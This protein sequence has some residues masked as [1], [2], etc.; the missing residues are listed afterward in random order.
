MPLALQWERK[1]VP[2]H[3]EIIQTANERDDFLCRALSGIYPRCALHQ[4]VPAATIAPLATGGAMAVY[5]ITVARPNQSPLCMVGKIP[6]DRRIVYVSDADQ[7]TAETTTHSLLTRLVRIAAHLAC[8]A[9]GIFPRSGGLWHECQADGAI[10]HLLMEEFIP[11]VSVERLTH[12]YDEQRTLGQLTMSD[13]QQC[14]TTVERL[15]VATF[16]RLWDTLGRQTFTSDPSPWNVLVRQAIPDHPDTRMAT[17][18][19]LHSLEDNATLSFVL[20]RLAAVYGMRQEVVEQLILPGLFDAVGHETGR[21]LLCA[22]LPHLEAQAYQ[23][24][25]NLGVDLQQPL[26]VAVRCLC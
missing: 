20:Q 12:T 23:T 4:T 1:P 16:I 9:P 21:A 8:H 25:R 3:V 7:H 18:I 22:E 11:G 10:H 19:D 15:A 2:S 26:L 5:K 13:Y 17:I 24:R 14:R 6:H